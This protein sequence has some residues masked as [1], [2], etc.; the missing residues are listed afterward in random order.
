MRGYLDDFSDTYPWMF[1]RIRALSHPHIIKLLFWVRREEKGSSLDTLYTFFPFADYGSLEELWELDDSK[2]RSPE[3]LLWTL[4]QIT[5]LADGLRVFHQANG[6][7]D[8]ICSTTILRFCEPGEVG[9][10][11]RLVIAGIAPG[12]RGVYMPTTW[13]RGSDRQ[14]AERKYDVLRPDS[15]AERQYRMWDVWSMGLTFLEFMLWLLHGMDTVKRFRRFRKQLRSDSD[16]GTLGLPHTTGGGTLDIPHTMLGDMFD[17]SEALSL[18]LLDVLKDSPQFSKSTAWRDI[19]S[20][21][22]ERVFVKKEDRCN[23]EELHSSLQ[24]ICVA[25]E[26]DVSYF[27]IAAPEDHG[28]GQ[29]LHSLRF[30]A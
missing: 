23:A 24:K 29:P 12:R 30:G 5:G 26:K 11:G 14:A 16:G 4:Q 25:T 28:G 1:D 3:L 19:L 17:A 2:P 8:G 13:N 22:I 21:L 18:V 7:L 27:Y 6:T 20:F 10:F 9:G 15:E